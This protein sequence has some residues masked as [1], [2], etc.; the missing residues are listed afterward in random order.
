[1]GIESISL[2][3]SLMHVTQLV[4]LHKQLGAFLHQSPPAY[5]L[6][7]GPGEVVVVYVSVLA[8]RAWVGLGPLEPIVNSILDYAEGFSQ[9]YGSQFDFAP[10][11]V[12]AL[13]IVV[14]V[15]VIARSLQ[16]PYATR[17]G[18][19]LCLLFRPTISSLTLAPDN[20]MDVVAAG[21]YINLIMADVVVARMA[22]RDLH[23]ILVVMGVVSSFYNLASI[24]LLV[25]YIMSVFSEICAYTKLTILS[26]NINVYCDG[27][28]DM[29]HIGHMKAFGHAAAFGTRLYVGV[30]NDEDSTVYKRTP[31]MTMD[32]RMEVVAACKCVYKVIPNAPCHPGTLTEEFIKEHNIH[33]VAH[34]A[35]Y[36][37]PT[38]KYYVVPRKLGIV[39]TTPRTQGW[40]IKTPICWGLGKIPR[41][42]I[43]ALRAV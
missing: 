35:E 28:F 6:L 4:L 30:C 32:E 17:N 18:V 16:L 20:L 21:L 14:L 13:L 27:I 7:D 36:D 3:W 8:A 38:D 23:P 22:K 34:G 10:S 12:H 25:F 43:R 11:P 41:A 42:G 2:Q 40:L 1:V 24:V 31:I 39:R 29:C 15:S 26:P 33:I 5:R 19:L 37:T 9:V